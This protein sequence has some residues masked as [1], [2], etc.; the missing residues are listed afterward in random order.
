MKRGLLRECFKCPCFQSQG[1]FK[2]TCNEFAQNILTRWLPGGSPVSPKLALC[3]CL[4]LTGE[5]HGTLTLIAHKKRLVR[6]V[7]LKL[8]GLVQNECL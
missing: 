6:C 8:A 3:M 7:E 2:A 1:Q 5:S 4:E